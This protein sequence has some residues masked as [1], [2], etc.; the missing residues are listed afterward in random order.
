MRKYCS[1]VDHC[2]DFPMSPPREIELKLDVPIPSVPALSRSSLF[3]ARA[4]S[5]RMPASLVSVYFDTKKLKLH[6]N[7]LSLRV[8]RTAGRHVQTIKKENGPSAGLFDR[9]EWEREIGTKQPD[10]D[11][12]SDTALAPCRVKSCDAA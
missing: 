10:L 7:A 1:T 5:A 6:K 8:R 12:A 11:A 3:K 4:A 9:N 2:V